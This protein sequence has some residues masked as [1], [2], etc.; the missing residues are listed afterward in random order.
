MKKSFSLHKTALAVACG[1]LLSLSAHADESTNVEISGQI[2]ANTCILKIEGATTTAGIPEKIINLGRN[3][4]GGGTGSTAP[5][6]GVP[7]GT[8]E[9]VNFSL[10]NPSGTGGCTA[11]PL[12]A[13]WNLILGFAPGSVKTIDGKKFVGNQALTGG[14]DAVVMLSGGAGTTTPTQISDLKET[15]TYTGTTVVPSN[16]DFNQSITLKA[17]LAYQNSAAA[18]PGVFE[19]AIPLLVSYN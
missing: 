4:T 8:A 18:T 7:F 10:G 1:A 9:S 19:A 13:K 14:T 12:G 11:A 2:S 15:M 3:V 17:Q 6:A 5:K 16:Q